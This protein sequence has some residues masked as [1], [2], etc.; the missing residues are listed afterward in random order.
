MS[1]FD[2]FSLRADYIRMLQHD[3]WIAAQEL[4]DAEYEA[5]Y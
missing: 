5:G 2:D 4:D 1:D 3:L